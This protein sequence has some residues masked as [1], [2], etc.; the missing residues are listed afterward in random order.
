MSTT[1]ATTTPSVK[2][3]SCLC[4]NFKFRAEGEPLLANLCHC[5]SCR[6]ITG[7]VFGSFVS[8]KDEQVT[9]ELATPDALRTYVDRSPESGA[10]LERSFCGTCGAPA[11]GR[12]RA[13]PGRLVLAMGLFDDDDVNVN[14]DD[15]GV[16]NGGAPAPRY[17]FYCRSR[18]PWLGTVDGA[19][20]GETYPPSLMKQE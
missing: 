11:V 16:R 19:E 9:L 17:E 20:R 1:T 15:E 13:H 3:G 4:G 12:S 6:K 10:P 14:G 8:Y 5:V 2:T 7:V 18:A